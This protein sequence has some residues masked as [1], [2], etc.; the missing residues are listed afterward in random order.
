[1]NSAI[2]MVIAMENTPHELS[3]SALTT[4]R[5]NT[6]MRM[7]MMTKIATI[8]AIPPTVPIS[9]RAIWPRLRPPR[10]VDITSTR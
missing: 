1:M 9:S 7:I 5:P 10:R 6:A 8:A 3:P 4:T 2:G